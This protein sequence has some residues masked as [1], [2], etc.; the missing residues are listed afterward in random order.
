MISQ[1]TNNKDSGFT[2]LE[3][4]VVMA[5]LSIL[6]GVLWANF[7]SSFSKGRDSKRKQDLVMVGRSLELYWNDNKKYP[8]PTNPL[9][10]WGQ[11]FP[12]PTNLAVIYMQRL[13]TDPAYPGSSYCYDSDDNGSY[14]KLYANLE[15]LRDSQ[16]FTTPLPCPTTGEMLYNYAITSTNVSP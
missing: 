1:T 12:H 5:I 2:L 16:V 3:L 7:S 13:P 15:N 6:A 10:S 11:P 9:P 14:Y 4:M 8:N